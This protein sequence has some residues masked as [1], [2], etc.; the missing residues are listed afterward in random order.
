MDIKTSKQNDDQFVN[1]WFLFRDC[2]KFGPLTASKIGDLLDKN[3]ITKDHHV[4]HQKYNSWV[5]IKDVDVFKSVGFEL[6]FPK[7]QVS[8]LEGAEQSNFSTRKSVFKE[9]KKPSLFKKLFGLF[10][11]KS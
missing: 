4:W 3:Q 9:A 10:A 1:E 6:Q 8:F 11:K 2:N 7:K 5:V